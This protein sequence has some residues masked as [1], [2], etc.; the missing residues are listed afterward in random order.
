MNTLTP[1]LIDYINSFLDFTTEFSVVKMVRPDAMMRRDAAIERKKVGGDKEYL[2]VRLNFPKFSHLVHHNK[3]EFGNVLNYRIKMHSGEFREIEKETEQTVII[4]RETIP[5]IMYMTHSEAAHTFAQ[6]SHD[7]WWHESIHLSVDKCGSLYHCLFVTKNERGEDQV[8]SPDEV[9]KK[10]SEYINR[11]VSDVEENKELLYCSTVTHYELNNALLLCSRGESQRKFPT[12]I[13]SDN[14]RNENMDLRFNSWHEHVVWYFYHT[15]EYIHG[16]RDTIVRHFPH[17]YE[18][19]SLHPTS[20]SPCKKRM[21][22]CGEPINEPYH[23]WKKLWFLPKHLNYHLMPK[24]EWV[25]FIILELALFGGAFGL[26]YIKMDQHTH[27]SILKTACV[28]YTTCFMW[29]NAKTIFNQLR[30]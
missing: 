17:I 5:V 12:F 9:Q 22:L 7:C 8:L 26:G 3:I 15:S 1:N 2:V 23:F 28:G 16:L 24:A 25:K 30:C 6:I 10:I 18:R 13:V 27:W 11:L 20:Q 29:V 19:R 21:I 4:H 14:S